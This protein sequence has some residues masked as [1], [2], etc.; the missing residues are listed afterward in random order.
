LLDSFSINAEVHGLGGN[1]WWLT[2]VYGPQDTEEKI[3]FLAKLSER[4]ALCHGP[5]MIIGDFNM[6]LR[7]SENNNANLDRA[8]IRHFWEFVADLELKE[9]YLHGRLFTWCNERENPTMTLIDRALVSVDWDLQN[10]DAIL[11]A[12]S[13]SVSDHA[14]LLLSL[15]SG[16]RPKR[17]FRFERFW[18]KL[19]GFE[20][21]VQE[22]WRCDDSIID[23]FQRLNELMRNSAL[24][25]QAWSQRAVGNVKLKIAIANLVIHKLDVTQ[26]RRVLSPGEHWLRRNLKQILLSL[27][28]LERT[29]ARQRSRMRWL[30]DGDANSKLFHSVANGR[31]A[32]NFIPS[33]HV[34]NTLIT[35]QLGKEN[36]FFNAYRE[37]LGTVEIREF[38]LDLVAL[39][40]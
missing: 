24:H 32:R 14:P 26:D 27:C 11:Q 22:G 36:A 23:P 15:N 10:P 8:S 17:R 37:L 39:G 31:K 19:E 4:R 5:W 28:S 30:R 40:V 13:S 21:A 34:G 9:L 33:V 29:I 16:H 25:L 20:E 38:D 1:A 7:A 6:I 35:D 3:Q 18:E 2:V 12:L